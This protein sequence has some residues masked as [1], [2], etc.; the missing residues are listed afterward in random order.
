M[1]STVDSFRAVAAAL[2]LR[3]D[4]LS[5]V[6]LEIVAG[7]AILNTVG[8]VGSEILVVAPAVGSETLIVEVPGIVVHTLCSVWGLYSHT[9]QNFG[10][11][12]QTHWAVYKFD[13]E[14]IVV[15]VEVD[16]SR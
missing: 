1:K 14:R 13:F 3:T 16:P 8:E 9:V 2:D 7:F 10:F 6:L 5:A 11:A 15:E 4:C 12:V